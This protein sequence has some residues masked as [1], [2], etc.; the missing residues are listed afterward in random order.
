MPMKERL[1]ISI[2]S[3]IRN[4]QSLFGTLLVALSFGGLISFV[5]LSSE[6]FVIG[7]G[8][9]E[10]A[11]AL[12][13]ATVSVGYITGGLICRRFL[14]IR[15]A[16]DLSRQTGYGFGI[17]AL[18]LGLCLVYQVTNFQVLMTIFVIYFA[19]IGAMLA[20]GTSIA[21]EPLGATAGM[22]AALLGTVQLVAGS[23][24]SLLLSVIDVETSLLLFVSLLMIALL[25]LLTSLIRRSS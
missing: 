7:L 21:L 6:V 12:I 15:A 9:S 16:T 11:Y 1:S 22:A 23:L 14:A 25:L 19:C 18:M 2:S 20:L 10:F 5:T 4:R 3:F 13:F 17:C 8:M 24:S